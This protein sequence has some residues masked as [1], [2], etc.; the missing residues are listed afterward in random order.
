MEPSCAT[1]L[2][3]W[4]EVKNDGGR[5]TPP[6]A[7]AFHRLFFVRVTQPLE[8]VGSVII[9]I[10]KKF[11]SRFFLLHLFL[12]FSFLSLSLSFSSLFCFLARSSVGSG[13]NAMENSADDDTLTALV[14]LSRILLHWKQIFTVVV[15]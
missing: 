8:Y 1:G 7:L 5:M 3:G 6:R 12:F 11:S 9:I 15:L 14:S 10:R 4:A 13:S 2:W